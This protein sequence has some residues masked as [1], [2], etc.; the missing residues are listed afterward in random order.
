MTFDLATLKELEDIIRSVRERHGH[1]PIRARYDLA[2]TMERWAK[3]ALND[4]HPSNAD[5]PTVGSIENIDELVAKLIDAPPAT[6]QYRTKQPPVGKR[7]P[8]ADYERDLALALAV[9][10]HEYTNAKPTRV[11]KNYETVHNTFDRDKTSPFYR[12][13]TASFNAIG[14]KPRDVTFREATERWERSRNFYKQ[15]FRLLI[16][17]QLP[18]EGKECRPPN[19]AWEE[20]RLRRKFATAL[21]AKRQ[22]RK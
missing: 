14:L 4:L 10:F 20:K 13:A 1:E 9:I 22:K 12:F 15:N 16:W 18:P 21:G 11:S 7:R 2:F 6:R 5:R 3:L 8:R 17:G 19:M